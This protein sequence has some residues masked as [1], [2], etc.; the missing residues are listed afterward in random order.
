MTSQMR[1]A[2]VSVPSNPGASGSK[3]VREN[4]GSNIFIPDGRGRFW[5]VKGLHYLFNLA[6][7]LGYFKEYAR[8]NNNESKIVGTAKVLGALI[9]ALR[10]T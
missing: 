7:R 5:K 2:T 1:I 6:K 8:A 10:K 4:V 3:D 9:R